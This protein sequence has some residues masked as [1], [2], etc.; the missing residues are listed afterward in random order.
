MQEVL[1]SAFFGVLGGLAYGGSAAIKAIK[2]DG[3]AFDVGRI[4]STCFVGAVFG[5]GNYLA[6][7]SLDLM[8]IAA[9]SATMTLVGENLWKAVK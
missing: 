8:Q 6:T 4:V 7:G 2:K 5:V 9:G 3:E 1:F